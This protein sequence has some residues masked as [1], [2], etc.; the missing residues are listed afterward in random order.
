MKHLEKAMEHPLHGPAVNATRRGG[1]ETVFLDRGWLSLLFF[2]FAL[3]ATHPAFAHI[4]K[5]EAGGFLSGMHHP[6]S[7]WDHI[8]AM[9][10]VGIWGAQLGAPAMW[11]LPVT[12][13]V[14]MAFGGMLGL[15]GMPL[16][17][18]EIG[19]AL[20]ALLLGIVVMSEARPPLWVAAALVGI[21]AIFHGY[22]HGTELPPGESGLLYSMGFVVAT[23][24]LHVVGITIGLIHRWVL[25]RRVLRLAGA[26]IAGGGV[27]FLVG[28]LG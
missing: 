10:A 13:P 15:M 26:V 12:F 25:G 6:I 7:G 5:G 18:A 2:V 16:P 19:I 4:M 23:G 3:F 11:L 8:L 9:V 22:A 20:S 21:F 17:G 27:Y 24:C 1:A 14:V 28:A